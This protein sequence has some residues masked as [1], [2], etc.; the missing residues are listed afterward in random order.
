MATPDP[1]ARLPA[2][3]MPVGRVVGVARQGRPSG[4]TYK[5]LI[6][7]I[8]VWECIYANTFVMPIVVIALAGVV[9]NSMCVDNVAVVRV[10]CDL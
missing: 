6:V 7:A 3:G 5:P 9:T 2:L 4:P 1:V 10:Y 8:R